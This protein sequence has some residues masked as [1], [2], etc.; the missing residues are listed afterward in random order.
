MARRV[1]DR[2]GRAEFDDAAEIH[3]AQPVRHVPHHRQVVADEQIGQAEP[4]LQVAHQVED[5][6]LHRHVQRRGG[7]VADQEFRLARQRAGDRDALALAAGELVRVFVAVGR[8][9]PDLRQQRARPGRAVPPPADDAEGAD[10]LGDDVAHPPARVQRGVRVLEDHV[11]P[12]AQVRLRA[13]GGQRLALEADFAGARRVEPHGEARDG[14]L[15]AAGLADQRQRRAARDGEGHGVHRA[16]QLPRSRASRRC[17]AGRETSNACDTSI[18]SSIGA[19][20]T[21]GAGRGASGIGCRSAKADGDRKILP[22]PLWEGVG[23]G[24][25]ASVAGGLHAP[26][27]PTPS[28]K[29]R[30]RM[31]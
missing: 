2:L 12:P 13:G 1:E 11:H 9:Q 4:C 21:A 27:P 23:G 20:A 24:V 25:R 16:Q 31:R 15:A 22:L 6:R 30:G 18:A 14:R 7:F 26:L 3:H 5:L 10:R 28:H 8:R 17:S 29:G 19:V